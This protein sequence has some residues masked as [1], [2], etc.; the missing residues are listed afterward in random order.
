MKTGTI[1]AIV[2]VLISVIATLMLVS[3]YPINVLAI[4]AGVA[5]YLLGKKLNAKK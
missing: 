3:K 5:I 4:G 1:V 2:G